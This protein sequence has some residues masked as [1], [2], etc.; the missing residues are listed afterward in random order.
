MWYDGIDFIAASTEQIMNALSS[1]RFVR[2][3]QLGQSIEEQGQIQCVIQFVNVNGPGNF[4][5]TRQI[6][7]F[8]GQIT[9]IVIHAKRRCSGLNEMSVNCAA[10]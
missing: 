3:L 6:F 5:A 2:M 8:N 9:A 1:V 10:G 7:H 4:L